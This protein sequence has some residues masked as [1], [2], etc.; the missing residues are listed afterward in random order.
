ML[1]KMAVIG[2]GTLSDMGVVEA[3][4]AAW[5][6]GVS[7]ETAS[8]LGPRIESMCLLKSVGF[9]SCPDGPEVCSG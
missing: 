5:E 4:V 6:P 2:D 9:P 1:P 3:V 7:D 8:C